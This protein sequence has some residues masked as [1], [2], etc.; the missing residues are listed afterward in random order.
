MNMPQ[1]TAEA[2]LPRRNYII[3]SSPRLAQAPLRS[4]VVP[5]GCPAGCVDLGGLC[6]CPVH[7]QPPR[8]VVIDGILHCGLACPPGTIGLWPNCIKFDP[9]QS[10]LAYC[11]DSPDIPLCKN[12]QT[13]PANCGSCGSACV[14]GSNCVAGKCQCSGSSSASCGN[15]GIKTRTCNSDGSWSDWSACM[16]EGECAPGSTQTCTNGTQTCSSNCQWGSCACNSSSTMCNGSCVNITDNN[17]HC[18][19]C[20][21]TCTG[22]L[23]C[24]GSSCVCSNSGTRCGTSH[25]CCAPGDAEC[26]CCPSGASSPDCPNGGACLNGTSCTAGQC[27]GDYCGQWLCQ[28]SHGNM[29]AMQ[30]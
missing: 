30:C 13:D 19:S 7:L 6:S 9:C 11:P 17:Q 15:C 18:G 29:T 5:A 4:Q 14:G 24:K 10:G 25:L 12:L 22:D 3:G 16:G 27:P 28:D 2:A 26:S 1:F 21:V 20:N 23:T 8:C